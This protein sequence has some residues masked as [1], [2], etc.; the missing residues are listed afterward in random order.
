MDAPKKNEF[1]FVSEKPKVD[2][3]IKA[4]LS[5]FY[6]TCL[7]KKCWEVTP[8]QIRKYIKNQLGSLATPP[9]SDLTSRLKEACS[10]GFLCEVNG[11]YSL[12]TKGID[13]NGEVHSE[14]DAMREL[15][16]KIIN[17]RHRR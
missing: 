2:K 13:V 5:E 10:Q 3:D 12:T 15:G 6:S 7:D 8:E 16:L 9:I 11:V 17:Y 14:F 4:T 1:L